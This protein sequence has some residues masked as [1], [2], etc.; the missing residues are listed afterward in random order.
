MGNKITIKVKDLEIK[1]TVFTVT[2][3]LSCII[4]L[5]H[6]CFLNKYLTQIIRRKLI[7]IINKIRIF[8]DV[9]EPMNSTETK[10]ITYSFSVYYLPDLSDTDEESKAQKSQANCSGH[11]ASKWTEFSSDLR[12]HILI[13]LTMSPLSHF[14]LFPHKK[15]K[16]YN[17]LL[18]FCHLTLNNY[19]IPQSTSLSSKKA[20]YFH[21]LQSI[22][23]EH[24]TMQGIFIQDFNKDEAYGTAGDR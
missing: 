22:I 18:F 12:V 3:S 11:T 13:L 6:F 7:S 21:L 8:L 23:T 1:D 10:L 17:L 24:K 2:Y 14:L 16:K 20:M 9:S 5:F 15:Q 4:L 19:H